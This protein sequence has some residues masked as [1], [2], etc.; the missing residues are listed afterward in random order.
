ML[1]LGPG[2]GRENWKTLKN[3]KNTLQDLEYNKKKNT[4]KRGK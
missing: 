4:E 2:I 1:T 3:E